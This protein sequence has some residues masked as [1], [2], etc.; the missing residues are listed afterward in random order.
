MEIQTYTRDCP[1]HYVIYRVWEWLSMNNII[2][3]ASHHRR[4]REKKYV[5]MQKFETIGEHWAS[6]RCTPGYYCDRGP[7][8]RLEWPF[9][10]KMYAS[11]LTSWEGGRLLLRFKYVKSEQLCKLSRIEWITLKSKARRLFSFP[12]GKSETIGTWVL[13][14][15]PKWICYAC[16]CLPFYLQK[17]YFI[18]SL[19]LSTYARTHAFIQIK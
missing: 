7:A 17:V 16:E 12:M 18:C 4:R 8:R 3:P 9:G 1:L 6:L 13:Q 5:A 2:Y 14:H 11:V 15:W 10:T 19:Q